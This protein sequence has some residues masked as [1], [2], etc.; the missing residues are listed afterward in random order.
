MENILK[1]KKGPGPSDH[2]L[3]RLQSKLRK[4]PLIYDL[5]KFDNVAQSSLW[6]IQ[7]ITSANLCQSIHGII[8]YS[9]LICTFEFRKWGKEGKKIQ[10][11]LKNTESFKEERKYIF[12]SLLRATIWWKNKK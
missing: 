8:N 2:L 5:T 12:H 10:K 6:V 11:Y 3:F 9:H 7:K 1:N 4:I